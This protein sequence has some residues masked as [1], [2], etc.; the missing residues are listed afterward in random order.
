MLGVVVVWCWC[1]GAA[2]AGAAVNRTATIF[3]ST[4]GYPGE[5]PERR[6]A[7]RGK[8]P[9]P[10][11]YRNLEVSDEGS[12]DRKGGPE[13]RR[14]LSL[15]DLVAK[16]ADRLRAAR[17][18]ARVRPAAKGLQLYFANVTYWS[19]KAQQYLEHAVEADALLA[20]ETH[21][22]GAELKKGLN[23]MEHWGFKASGREAALTGRS[24]AGAC[25][26]IFAAVAKGL[27]SFGMGPLDSLDAFVSPVQGRLWCGR[28]VRLDGRDLLVVAVYLP[29]GAGY[30]QQRQDTLQDLGHLL[31]HIRGGLD[32]SWRLEPVP[33]GAR[34]EW[35]PGVRAGHGGDGRRPAH[36]PTR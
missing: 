19:D 14:V 17:A 33:P 35:L 28:S 26:G 10:P 32:P 5:G 36:L 9:P 4:K 31:K 12:E 34:G 2:A 16:P 15:Y 27:A 1:L 25:G 30:L 18:R 11:A 6:V 13:P 22:R 3:D 23:R 29:P 7:I 8:Q 21:V 24:E 20:V